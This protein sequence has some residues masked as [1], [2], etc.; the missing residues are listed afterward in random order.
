MWVAI[1]SLASL[2]GLGAMAART[3]GAGALRA[4]VRVMGWGALAMIA[5]AIV[6]RVFGAAV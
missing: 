5:T 2:G 3:G 1:G 4:T 6:G